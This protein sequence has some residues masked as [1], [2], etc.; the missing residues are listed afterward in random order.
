MD[1]Q[2]FVIETEIVKHEKETLACELKYEC[3]VP[4]A[5]TIEFAVGL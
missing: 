1:Q 2:S 5:K 3:F 4:V